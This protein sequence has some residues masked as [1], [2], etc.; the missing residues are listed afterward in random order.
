MRTVFLILG[1]GVP[2]NINQD[3]NYKTYLKFV[4]NSIYDTVLKNKIKKPLIIF[5][6]GKTDIFKPYKRSEAGEMIKF[7]KTLKNRNFVR[8]I[9]RDWDLISEAKPLTTLE[10]L[11]FSQEILK[12]KKINQ[13]QIYIFCELTRV[14][15]VRVLANK[16]L[17]KKY[18]FKVIGID[19]DH[20]PNR[21]LPLEFIRQKEAEDIKLALWAL[22]SKANLKKYHQIFQERIEYFRQQGPDKHLQAIQDWWQKKVNQLI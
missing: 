9:T 21:Y 2:K 7:F 14:K 22:K 5:S 1:Y 12:K 17:T 16:V 13:A 20:S 11:L 18:K 6:G 10:N 15:K 8:E 3:E 4:F 19:F